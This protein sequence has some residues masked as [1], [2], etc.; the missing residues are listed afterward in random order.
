MG[1]F[2]NLA[3]VVKGAIIQ[4]SKRVTTQMNHVD[5]KNSSEEV[6]RSKIEIVKFFSEIVQECHKI[7]ILF[8]LN[9]LISL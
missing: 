2:P 8:V 3:F 9:F 6:Q 7:Q 5:P 1:D 4:K